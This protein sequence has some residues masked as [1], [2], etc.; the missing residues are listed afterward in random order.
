LTLTAGGSWERTTT[1]LK[2]R[3]DH[4]SW[5]S[6]SGTILMGGWDSPGTS[7]KIDESGTSS[8][9]FDLEYDTI[10]A[11]AINLGSSVI[12][13]GGYYSPTLTRVSEYDESGFIRN[14]PDLNR[15]RFGHG[16]SYYEDG[17]GRKTYLVSGGYNIASTEVLLET[18][19]AWTL[20]GQLPSP[21]QGPQAARIDNK[22]VMTG[23]R[24]G[25]GSS[26]TFYDEILEKYGNANP[27]EYCMDVFNY[28]NTSAVIDG[29]IMCV[30]GGLSPVIKSLSQIQTLY[31]FEEIPHEGAIA[32]MMWA[33][34]DDID[35]W[36]QSPRGAG[37]LF[38]ARVT[39]E[40]LQR[41]DLEL[42]CRAHQLVQEGFKYMFPQKN[43]VTVW[44]APN[45]CYR[46]GN[47]ASILAFDSELNREFRM[48]REVKESQLGAGGRTSYFL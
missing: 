6:P 19:T 20:T 45:Y 44:S 36:A 1:L 38:G 30:H 48:F 10:L 17:E 5:A 26:C 12:L 14:L 3:S 8:Y 46:C 13:T 31:R 33:D 43:L 18:D 4:S 25:G 7:E 15:G 9:S 34:P 16:C 29:S 47:V 28:F 42:I 24:N 35:G 21:R 22:I 39:S 40:F 2:E 41:N 23:G 11:C 27:W 37:F 32:D